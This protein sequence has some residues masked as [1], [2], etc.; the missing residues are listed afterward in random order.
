MATNHASVQL[1]DN[2]LYEISFAGDEKIEKFRYD[3]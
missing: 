1:K 3:I 2:S